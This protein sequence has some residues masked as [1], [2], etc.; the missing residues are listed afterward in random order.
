MKTNIKRIGIMVAV[1]S[2]LAFFVGSFYLQKKVL[3]EQ[4]KKVQVN[5]NVPVR[6]AFQKSTSQSQCT[7]A[8]CFY[9]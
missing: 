2:V 8:L 5:L 3:P 7:R 4:I 9:Y 1:L 6:Y